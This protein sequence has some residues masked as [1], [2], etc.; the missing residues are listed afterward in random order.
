MPLKH[1]RVDPADMPPEIVNLVSTVTL[2]PPAPA[3]CYKM[4]LMDATLALQ[5]AQFAPR[6]FAAKIDKFRQETGT[7]TTLNFSTGQLVVVAGQT[8]NDTRYVSQMERSI[9]EQVEC[10]MRN[11]NGELV[12]GT[13]MGRT[14]FQNCHTHNIVGHGSVGFLLDLQAMQDEYPACCKY[15]PDNFPGLALTLWNN[16]QYRCTCPA[17]VR[18]AASAARRRPGRRTATAAAAAAAGKKC[19]CMTQMLVFDSGKVVIMGE[20]TV[21]AVNSAFFRFRAV[22]ERFRSNEQQL[23]R[24]QR[25]DARVAK[26]KAPRKRHRPAD[27]L[28]L[29]DESAIAAAEPKAI[30]LP[31]IADADAMAAALLVTEQAAA[32]A[33]VVK[34]QPTTAIKRALLSGGTALMRLA[35]AGRHADVAE[36]LALDPSEAQRTDAEGRTALQRLQMIPAR[37][38]TDGHK[39]AAELIRKAF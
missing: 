7:V 10:Y 5:C 19:P 30:V 17:P 31:T 3:G 12:R 21:E 6:V 29:R 25:Y 4:P 32:S 1:R 24:S 23:Q 16:D 2:L 28:D 35:E 13:L 8:P 22:A 15:D 38:Q 26:M 20:D 36:L 27:A 39:R 33:G 37:E 18:A 9:L 14:V 34:V 11:D